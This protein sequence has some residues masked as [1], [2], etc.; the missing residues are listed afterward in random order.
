MELYGSVSVIDATHF[1]RDQALRGQCAGG[2]G[3]PAALQILRERL[4]PICWRTLRRQVQDARHID[5]RKRHAVTFTFEPYD[6]EA[7]LYE[8]V[9]AY[10]QDPGTIAYGGKTNALVL[11]S[12]RKSLGSSTFAVGQ[13]LATLA[14]RLRQKQ[15]AALEMDADLE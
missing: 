8:R 5:L 10:L 1:G 3:T 14:E 11:L 12:A 4:R 6:R 9:S 15:R 13:Y 2:A 7:E